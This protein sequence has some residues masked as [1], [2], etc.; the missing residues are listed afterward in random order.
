MANIVNGLKVYSTVSAGS[1]G[2][3]VSAVPAKLKAITFNNFNT[4]TTNMFLKVYNK[5]TAAT[6]SDTPVLRLALPYNTGTQTFDFGNAGDSSVVEEAGIAFDTGIS[7]RLTGAYAD[8]DTTA[9]TAGD[10]QINL[11]YRN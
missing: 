8:A 9:P 1:T 11:T 5:A 7:I 6:A 3:V 2:L 4:G 10:S